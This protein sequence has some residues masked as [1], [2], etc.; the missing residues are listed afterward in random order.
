MVGAVNVP[1]DGVG[2]VARAAGL[3]KNVRL[4]AGR[5]VVCYARVRSLSVVIDGRTHARARNLHG[6]QRAERRLAI[7]RK[8]ALA[9]ERDVD[10]GKRVRRQLTFALLQGTSTSKRIE[11]ILT[12][13]FVA[14]PIRGMWLCLVRREDEHRTLRCGKETVLRLDGAVGQCWRTAGVEELVSG[15]DAFV[16]AGVHHQIRRTSTGAAVLLQV[17]VDVP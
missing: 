14:P 1:G 4:L 7:E 9:F 12:E 11:H 16:D 10:A 13:A 17:R 6:A 15:D 3:G 5:Q 8:F 2:E